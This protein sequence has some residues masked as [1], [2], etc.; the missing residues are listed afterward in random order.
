MAAAFA[1]RYSKLVSGLVL[2]DPPI[3]GP[4]QRGIYPYPVTFYLE[5][6]AAVDE[7]RLDAFRKLLP[8]SASEERVLARADELRNCSQEA[9]I[10]SYVSMLRE[11][12]QVH[13][14]AASCP[15]LLLA[16]EHGD[17]IRDAELNTLKRINPRLRA[18][19][20]LGVG[21]MVHLDAPERTAKLI[22]DFIAGVGSGA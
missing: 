15:M 18:E 2:I 11:P 14:K 20:V 13:V 9:I 22:A 12:F 10:E 19:K 7:G 3:N 5:Q 6:K 16:A 4:G 21:H 1:G 8:P 17:T